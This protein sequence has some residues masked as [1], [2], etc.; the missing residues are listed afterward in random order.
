MQYKTSDEKLKHAQLLFQDAVDHTREA[1][2]EAHRAARFYHNTDCE[3]QWEADDLRYLKDQ[4]RPAMTFNVIKGKLDTFL[5]MY[6]DAQR[7][8]VVVGSTAQKLIADVLNAV[9]DQALEDAGYKRKA[10]RQ[11]KTGSI[12]GGCGLLLEVVPSPDGPGW[13]KLNVYR[14]LPYEMH[15]DI[16]S[17]EPDRSDAR[18]WFWD[19][20]LDKHEFMSEYPHAAKEWGAVSAGQTDVAADFGD[21]S[22]GSAEFGPEGGSFDEGDYDGDSRLSRYYYNRRKNKIRVIR[23]EY[24]T[25][26]HVSYAT[27][28]ETQQRTE[29]DAAMKKRIEQAI[30]Q[31]AQL[32]IMEADEDVVEVCEFIGTKLLAEYDSAG[33]FDGFSVVPYCYEVDEETGTAYG[34]VRN[35]F[36]PQQEINKS[37]S[38]EMEHH[39]QG[40]APGVMAEED[41]IT[42]EDAFSD[43]MRRSGGVAIV[44]KGAL[45]EGRVI[46][47][48]MLPPSLALS[49]RFNKA[50][51]AMD[52]IS[53]IPD[54]S[55]LTAAQHAQSGVTVALRYNKS[56]QAVST[57]FGQHEE[58][59]KLFIEK[60]CHAIAR[61][62]PDAQIQAMLADEGK[63]I[64][65]DGY[66]V[67]LGED[68]QQP[69]QM[70]PKARA[71]LRDLRSFQWK[72]DMEYT[73]ENST[74]AMMELEGLLAV[75]AVSP[76]T[77]DPFVIA[78][79]ASSSKSTRE[80]LKKYLE[81]KQQAE[82]EAGQRQAQVMAE[83]SQQYGQIEGGKIQ[84]TQ[85]HNTATEQLKQR[86]LEIKQR[87]ETAQLYIDADEF[88][89]K[90][91]LE[92]VMFAARQPR[93]GAGGFVNG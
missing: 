87:L 7:A 72:F 13:I 40:T 26:K 84:E 83:Q 20:W 81:Q 39:A 59:Q 10:S 6:W 78:E 5:G 27:D 79:R 90:R 75:E 53:T 16:A 86:E 63:Y 35:L 47:R 57:P 3:G 1:N 21:E 58:A 80:R 22:F 14:I 25:T 62:M 60:V 49:E 65:Q 85:R 36:D 76:G 41:A 52:S 56:K 71:N 77:I 43:E 61:S 4:L 24:K 15:W 30:R 19:R 67:E 31:G 2:V 45:T 48:P 11:L 88:E 93:A 46:D 9:K 54:A 42:D 73:S 91:I 70:V 55:D 8:P 32:E 38:L 74:L 44:K 64:F 29:I 69:G 68:S 37:K 28:L 66:V 23:Y 18:H 51:L 34:F 12:S 82:S 89:K 92:M 50:M 17:I 33:P